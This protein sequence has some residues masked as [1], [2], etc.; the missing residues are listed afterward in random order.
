MAG[1]LIVGG[2]LA[3]LLLFGKKKKKK[4]TNG[5]GKN[6]TGEHGGSGLDDPTKKKTAGGGGSGGGSQGGTG[7]GGGAP[8]NLATD[9]IW[10]SPDCKEVVYGDETGEAFWESK[11]LAV[12]QNFINANYHDPY[13][14]ARLMVFSMAP[15]A[16]EFPVQDLD[17][18]DPMEEEFRRELFNRNFKDV[19][20]LIQFL[21]DKVAALMGRENIIIEFDDRCDVV[22][23]GKNWVNSP[24]ERMARFY[25]EY[26][27]PNETNYKDHEKRFKPWPLADVPEDYMLWGDNVATAIINRMHPKCGIAIAEAFKKDPMEADAFFSTR[28]GLRALY[29][30]LIDFSGDESLVTRIFLTRKGGID[31]SKFET[32]AS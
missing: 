4:K 21:H 10:V 5:D 7:K 28:P 22:F 24:A 32:I 12:A 3:L 23:V 14:I 31:F 20:Y 17:A 2:G 6:G 15:C 9:A 25:V 11:G 13:E 19:Y 16:V 30:S 27:Y 18:L 26:S 8:S 1:E 29:K